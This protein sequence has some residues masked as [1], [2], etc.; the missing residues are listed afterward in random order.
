MLKIM[1]NGQAIDHEAATISVLDHGFLYGDMVYE[2]V[3]VVNGI[4]FAVDMH[5][6]RMRYSAA[7][8]NLPI[9]WEDTFIKAEMAKMVDY[10]GCDPAYL[11]LVITRGAGSLSLEPESCGEQTRILYGKPL[12]PL[13]P[14]YYRKGVGLWISRPKLRDKGNIKSAVYRNNV[15]AIKKARSEGFHEALLLGRDGM[16]TECTTSNIFWL[17]GDI[18]FTPALN[19][20]ILKG[21]T[22]QLVIHLASELGLHVREG[23]Y[24][25]ETLLAADEVFLTS[26]TR[27]VMPVSRVGDSILGVGETTRKL[28]AGFAELGDISLDWSMD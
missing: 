25:L 24:P 2:V 28:M 14:E 13:N 22:R 16:I 12:T 23:V 15:Q 3:K 27:D 4:Y 5:L 21:V 7:M 9:P 19:V 20:G 1:I 17:K 18:L 11:R 8:I 10:L 26:T 6:Q